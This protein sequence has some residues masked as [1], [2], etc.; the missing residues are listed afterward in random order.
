MNYSCSL[1]C[2]LS[3]LLQ[4]RLKIFTQ[5]FLSQPQRHSLVNQRAC[6]SLETAH[7]HILKNL[8]TWFTSSE[9]ADGCEPHLWILSSWFENKRVLEK[10]N[11]FYEFAFHQDLW[12]ILKI[13]RITVHLYWSICYLIFISP[14][15]MSIFVS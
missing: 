13:N 9:N 6:G 5:C 8:N 1:I 2:L 3:L 10:L 7:G 14:F 4:S 11:E 12:F 15:V